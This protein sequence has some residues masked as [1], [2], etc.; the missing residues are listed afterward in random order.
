MK[1]ITNDDR[2]AAQELAKARSNDPALMDYEDLKN[3]FEEFDA[4]LEKLKKLEVI[5]DDM[6][7]LLHPSHYLAKEWENAKE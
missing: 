2:L 7:R 1:R 6:C 5:G 4:A 3:L